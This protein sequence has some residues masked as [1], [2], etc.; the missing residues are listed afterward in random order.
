MGALHLEIEFVLSAIFKID[1]DVPMLVCVRFYAQ[2][3][4]FLKCFNSFKEP[5]AMYIFSC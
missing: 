5:Y 1:F 3:Q 2:F 4:L